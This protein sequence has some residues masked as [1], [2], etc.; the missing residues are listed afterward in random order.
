MAREP[1]SV[2]AWGEVLWDVYPDA[3][4]LGG[5][6]TNFAF[7]LARIGGAVTLISRVGDDARGRRAAAALAAAGVDTAALQVDREG[8]P[9]GVVEVALEG[10]EARYTLA[11]GSAW[12]AIEL[13]AGAGAALGG[14]AAFYTG[15]LAGRTPLASAPGG[16]PRGSA[17]LGAAIDALPAGARVVLDPNL[18]G[19]PD[20]PALL[21]ALLGRA[22]VVKLNDGELA[23][24]AAMLGRADPVAELVARGALVAVTH[25]ARGATLRRGAEVVRHR[26]DPAPPGGDSVGCGDAFTAV[27]VHLALAGAGLDRIAAAACGYA[28][29]VAA[30]RGATPAIPPDVVDRLIGL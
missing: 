1:R 23:T 8:R 6:P 14:A 16:P 2:V 20:D 26:G 12:E 25:G 13:D 17:A 5:A 18:R 3:E 11:R 22:D 4:H 15:T 9:T 10:G 24:I 21:A 7:H 30:A 19:G 29:L 27:L 28:A